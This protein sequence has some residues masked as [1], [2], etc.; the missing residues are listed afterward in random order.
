[1][2]VSKPSAV[3][4]AVSC[5]ESNK[6]FQGP[7]QLLM[8]RLMTMVMVWMIMI[9]VALVFVLEVNFKMKSE[10]SKG[11]L[12]VEALKTHEH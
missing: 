11:T 5:K 9:M 4:Q 8:T 12:K 7:I 6:T 1:M 10:S 3:R 2:F